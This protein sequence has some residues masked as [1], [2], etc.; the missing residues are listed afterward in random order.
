M[1]LKLGRMRI[2]TKIIVP[3]IVVLVLS[4][5]LST[6]TSAYKMNDMA[7]DNAKKALTQTTDSIFL[8]LR[9]AMNTGDSTVIADAEEKSRQE[10]SGLKNLTVA[11]SKKMI[12][13][14][15]PTQHFTQDEAIHKV[16]S[17]KKETVLEIK[18]DKVHDLRVIRPMLATPECLYCHVNQ[19]E[20][21]VIGVL[22]LTFSLLDSDE[23]I[24]NTILNLTLQAIIVLI[25]IT[26]F[27][28]WLIRKATKPIDVFQQGLEK[29]FR[30][31]NKQEDSVDH[32]HGY[33]NDEIGHLVESVNR[34][35]DA[36]V[37]GLELD[38]AVIAEAKE[39]CEKAALGI[40]DVSI[41]SCAHNPEINKLKDTVN[42]FISA[43][44]YNVTRIERILN[45]YDHDDYTPRIASKGKTTGTMKQV[46]DKIDVLG[47]TLSTF[48]KQNLDNGIRLQKDAQNLENSVSK[49]EQSSK[50]QLHALQQTGQELTDITQTVRETTQAANEMANYAKVVT[51]S[52][53]TGQDLA[54]KTAS[55]MD[56]ITQQVRAINEAI[57]II[58]Q[59]AFQ[60]NILSLNAAVEAATAGEAGKGFAVVAA[61]V[62]NLANK[63][64]EAASDIKNLVESAISKTDEGKEIASKMTQEYD[65]LNENITSTIDLIEKVTS[66]SMNQQKGIEQIND[67]IDVI[68][69]KTVENTQMAKDA[70][71][72]SGQTSSLAQTIVNDAKNKKFD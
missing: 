52:V 23:I 49:I 16:F 39:V 31:I 30:F 20:G 47:E 44:G 42:Q 55:E 14:F 26:F 57:T 35:I 17:S 58:D 1:I 65:A 27:M 25:F 15:N 70:T 53:N 12:E 62:R 45:S 2:R 60:T 6:F 68:E 67:E 72:I 63:S 64:A 5:L 71:L 29:F 38:E 46:F 10:I 28:T 36:T 69:K 33:S 43:V 66:A 59:I 51:Q 32:I 34:N 22:D 61:E 3:T 50:Q 21:D 7:K 40:Y 8:N 41:Q 18:N 11:K 4:N 37:E 9:T 24:N 13:L 56:E 19:Q 48:S 54:T